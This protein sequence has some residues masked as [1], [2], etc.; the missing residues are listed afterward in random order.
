M[1]VIEFWPK[2]WIAS[3]EWSLVRSRL[4]T[5]AMKTS[6][7]PKGVVHAVHRETDADALTTVCGSP[8][9]QLVQFPRRDFLH[10]A[11]PSIT[12]PCWR[13]M[14]V[15]GHPRSVDLPGLTLV[16]RSSGRALR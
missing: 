13:C 15:T 6:R 3:Q 2:Y 7:V 9:D 14:K 5:G 1:S 16:T 12:T 8:I 11:L 10:D 4:S